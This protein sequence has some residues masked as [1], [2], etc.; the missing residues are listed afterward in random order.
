MGK[1]ERMV[2][3]RYLPSLNSCGTYHNG[4]VI[5]VCENSCC[6]CLAVTVVISDVEYLRRSP[7]DPVAP[8]CVALS[9]IPHDRVCCFPHGRADDRAFVAHMPATPP[10]SSQDVGTRQLPALF[11]SALAGAYLPSVASSLIWLSCCARLTAASTSWRR[12][13]RCG[14]HSANGK[15]AARPS[16]WVADA[17]RL[18]PPAADEPSSGCSVL[19]VRLEWVTRPTYC[20][21]YQLALSSAQPRTEVLLYCSAARWHRPY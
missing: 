4:A 19:H 7:F 11:N 14:R 2:W 9:K 17:T 5:G 10:V 13:R 3:H 1:Y 18:P 6:H 8:V 16:N 12:G 21:L 15:T 20:W